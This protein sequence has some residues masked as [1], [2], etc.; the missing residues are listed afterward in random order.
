MQQLSSAMLPEP[1]MRLFPDEPLDAALR[2]LAVRARIQ[3]V[4]RMRPDEVIGTLSL[5]DV[6]EAYGI[7]DEHTPVQVV[8]IG[9]T[10]AAQ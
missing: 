5:H 7:R 3:V 2:L 6:H 8:G 9:R 4:S 1:G 10:P